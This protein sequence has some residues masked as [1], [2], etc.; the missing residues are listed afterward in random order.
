MLLTS[1]II[2]KKNINIK[3]DVFISFQAFNK[4]GLSSLATSWA[5]RVD[6][7]PPTAG[8]VY[9]GDRSQITGSEKDID[10][11]TETKVLHSYWEGFHDSHSTIKEYYI[12]IGTCRLCQDILPEQAIGIAYGGYI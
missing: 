6:T 2:K 9:D 11:Q 5:F 3:K 1:L 10:F 4:A 7:T 12:S 8:H